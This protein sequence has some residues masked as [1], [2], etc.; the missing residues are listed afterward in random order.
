MAEQYFKEIIDRRGYKVDSEDRGI[1]EKEISKSNFGLGCADMIEFILYDSNNNQLPQGDNG[2]M[3]RYIYIDEANISDYFIMSNNNLTKKKDGTIEF[4]VDIEKLIVEAGYN[5]GIFRTQVTL[6]NRR[7][8]VENSKQDNLWI[9]EIS[10]S[11]T[12]LRVLPNRASKKIE[13][14]EKRYGIF[15]DEKNFRD[16]VIYY[17]SVFI[18][19]INLQKVFEDMLVS[20][21][22]ETDGTKYVNLITK[23]FK[24]DSFELFLQR[25][26]TKFIE[27]MT[28][29]SQKRVWDINDNRYG[30]PVGEEYDCVELSI[31]DV[32]NAAFQTLITIIDYY[33]PKRDIITKSVLTKEEQIT[34]D[35]VKRILKTTTS[36]N[37]YETTEPTD[38]DVYGCTDPN[39]ITYNEFATIDDGSCEYDDPPIRGCTDPNSKNYNPLATEDD[40]SCDDGVESNIEKKKYYIWSDEGSITYKNKD[41]VFETKSGVMYDSFTCVH[42]KGSVTFTGDVREVPKLK[43][44]PKNVFLYQIENPRGG[45][46]FNSDEYGDNVGYNVSPLGPISVTYIDASGATKRSSIVEPG[47]STTICA[48][49]GSIVG[50][51]ELKITKQGD[52]I[53][54]DLGGNQNTGTTTSSGVGPSFENNTSTGGSSGGSF[55]GGPL[56]GPSVVPD[57][58]TPGSP[59]SNLGPIP[60][61]NYK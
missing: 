23:E 15:T 51:F 50:P 5:N 3:V 54:N 60:I 42:I 26:K 29:Y 36:N 18:E 24:L 47:S 37:I 19:N 53:T 32:E 59:S 41:G 27:S 30:K 55:G 12:E 57:I 33:L 38:T 31:R 35:K 61:I 17:V 1:F 13:D 7:A 11:R 45:D 22:K 4:I 58:P 56:T 49:E 40:G 25:I 14:L 39:S 8:G 48:Q 16:D 46:V 10:P 21:G 2:D 20:K 34:L 43:P 52:C 28:Y 44:I 6:L 9:H